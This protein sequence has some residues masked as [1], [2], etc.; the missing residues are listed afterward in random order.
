MHDAQTEPKHPNPDLVAL[1]VRQPWA[2]L[3]VRGIKTVEVRSQNTEVRGTIYIYAAR[4]LA[5]HPGADAAWE[6][7]DLDAEALPRGLIVGTVEIADSAPALKDHAAAACVPAEV[8]R[9]Q[10]A[11]RLVEPRRIEPLKPRFLPYGIW[12]YPFKRRR[13]R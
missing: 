8:L 10:H 3:I 6:K 7:Y 9:N 11:W 2:E 4:K 5:E 13:T 12:F 1:G